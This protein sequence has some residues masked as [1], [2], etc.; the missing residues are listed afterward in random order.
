MSLLPN[1]LPVRR[2]GEENAASSPRHFE[3]PSPGAAGS[4]LLHLLRH[5]ADLTF[6]RMIRGC[7]AAILR[8]PISWP[9]RPPATLLP[10]SQCVDNYTHRLCKLRLREADKAPQSRDILSRLYL[11]H[12]EPFA[13][14]TRNGPGRNCCS[15]SSGILVIAARLRHRNDTAR[16]RALLQ[17]AR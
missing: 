4:A 8:R 11:T 14:T 13:K 7:R 3:P 5:A 6:S 9:V 10:V 15:V 12:H 16:P 2:G 1:G 17:S